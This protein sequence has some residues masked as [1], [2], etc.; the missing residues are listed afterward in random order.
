MLAFGNTILLRRMGARHAV[1]NPRA[2]EMS[3]EAMILATPIGL[4]RTDF[5][6]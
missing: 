6:V 1:R 4:D 5:S 2:L 3:M